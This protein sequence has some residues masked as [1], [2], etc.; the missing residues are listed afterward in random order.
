MIFNI[1]FHYQIVNAE[2]LFN[3]ESDIKRVHKTYIKNN[4]FE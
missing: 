2:L 1:S 4:E 3:L